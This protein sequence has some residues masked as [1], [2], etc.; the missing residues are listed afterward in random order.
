MTQPDMRTV[1]RYRPKSGPGVRELDERMHDALTDLTAYAMVFDIECHRLEDRLL[2]LSS[3]QSSAAECM[4]LLR[5]RT[6]MAEELIAF[7]RTVAT[8][9]EEAREPNSDPSR[10]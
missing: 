3:D 2:A 8:F 5:E 4:A 7:R 10:S 9:R 6:E 1:P